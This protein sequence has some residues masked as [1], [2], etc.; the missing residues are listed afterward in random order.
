M[1]EERYVRSISQLLNYHR[2]SSPKFLKTVHSEIPALHFPAKIPY[3]ENIF[4]KTALLHMANI[5]LLSRAV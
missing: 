3:T 4:L 1:R 2:V 5:L